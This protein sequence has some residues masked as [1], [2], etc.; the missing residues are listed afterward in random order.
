MAKPKNISKTF[1]YDKLGVNLCRMSRCL[2]KWEWAAENYTDAEVDVLHE[3]MH[4]FTEKYGAVALGTILR[5]ADALE[6]I[7]RALRRGES[8]TKKRVTKRSK[9]KGRKR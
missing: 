9:A 3:Q 5:V 2:S 6:G 7:E 1:D 8:R 4:E